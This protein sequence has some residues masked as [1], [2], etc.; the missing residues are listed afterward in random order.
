MNVSIHQP[1]YLPWLPLLLKIEQSDLFIFLDN[2]DFQKNG[3][4][5]RNQIKSSQGPIWLTV[6][7]YHKLGQKIND[8]KIDNS[9]NWRKKHWQSIQLCY[10]NAPFFKCYAKD[11]EVIYINEWSSLSDLNIE[12]TNM[13]MKWMGIKT[14]IIRSS[15]MKAA[16]KASDLIHNLCVEVGATSYIS[17]I[18]GKEYLNSETFLNSNIDLFYK[19]YSLPKKYPQLFN[20]SGFFNDLSVIDILFNCGQDWRNYIKFEN[21]AQ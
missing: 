15:Q 14:P 16:G 19:S 10:R 2:V 12:T 17:G 5:N 8:V 1:Q 3:L 7:T 13:L 20:Q 11:L 9:K 4:Q 21:I 18:G 6:P